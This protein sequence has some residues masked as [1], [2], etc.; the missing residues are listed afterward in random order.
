MSLLTL[1]RRDSRPPVFN[2]ELWLQGRGSG[3]KAISSGTVTDWRSLGNVTGNF[4]KNTNGTAVLTSSGVQMQDTAFISPNNTDYSFIMNGEAC[5]IF[6]SFTPATSAV[7]T[8]VFGCSSGG[9]IRGFSFGYSAAGSPLAIIADGTNNLLT[10]DVNIKAGTSGAICFNVANVMHVAIENGTGDDF[11]QDV[12]CA[13]GTSTVGAN[14]VASV[15][16]YSATSTTLYNISVGALRPG[17]NPQTSTTPISPI[18]G[19]ITD[20]LIY[21]RALTSEQVGNIN[22]WMANRAGF[23]I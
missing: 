10:G 4:D 12:Y 19:T 1:F 22:Q 7:S 11:Q 9:T 8:G 16:G 14:N 21:R 17:N 3:T 6:M 23:A 18:D 2:Y 20:I 5:H 15:S 13:N